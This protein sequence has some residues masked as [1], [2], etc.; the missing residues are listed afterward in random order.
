MLTKG[1]QMDLVSFGDGVDRASV[2]LF[3]CNA[4]EVDANKL[5]ARSFSSEVKLVQ[6]CPH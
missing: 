2:A 4:D 6:Q 3:Y 5:R 1:L